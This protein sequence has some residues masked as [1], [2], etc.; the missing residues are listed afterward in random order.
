MGISCSLMENSFFVFLL[1]TN[2]LYI[3]FGPI[4]KL[5]AEV[6][7]V[8]CNSG[9]NMKLLSLFSKICMMPLGLVTALLNPLLNSLDSPGSSYT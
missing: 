1:N 6:G 9:G 5:A 2:D 4:L 3:R 7:E 8:F